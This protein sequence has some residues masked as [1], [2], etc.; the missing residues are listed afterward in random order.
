[1]DPFGVQGETEPQYKLKE[2]LAAK[3]CHIQ[4]AMSPQIEEGK[5]LCVWEVWAGRCPK[6]CPLPVLHRSVTIR[7][8]AAGYSGIHSDS[9]LCA[10]VHL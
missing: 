9:S 2:P 6:H 4:P 1:M 3:G 5:N 10:W 8:R 7:A